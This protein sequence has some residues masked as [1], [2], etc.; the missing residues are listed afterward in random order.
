M[1]NITLITGAKCVFM[2]KFDLPKAC[3]IIQDHRITF[4]YVPPPIILAF[5]KHPIID[6]YD[7][8]SL[9]FINSAAAPLSRD[10][11]D[12]VW[13]R[14]KVAVKQGYGLSETS[15]AVSTQLMEEWAKYI[16]SI[17]K[18]VPNMEAKIVDEQGKEV[19]DGEVLFGPTI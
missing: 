18:L 11:V 8:S 19:P 2:S 17:G 10:L 9:R 1:L 12:A 3:Q 14:L 13:K 7:L 5:G 6:K 16:G 15:P 4:I